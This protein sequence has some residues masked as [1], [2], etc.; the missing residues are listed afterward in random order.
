[1]KTSDDQIKTAQKLLESMENKD[2]HTHGKERGYGY[3]EVC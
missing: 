3:Y 1:M 2:D